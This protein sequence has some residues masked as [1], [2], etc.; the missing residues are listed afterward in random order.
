MR[1]TSP[2]DCLEYKGS[3]VSL[4]Q[5]KY[6]VGTVLDLRKLSADDYRYYAKCV[7]REILKDTQKIVYKLKREGY[8]KGMVGKKMLPGNKEQ[9]RLKLFVL[10]NAHTIEIA[11]ASPRG[12]H[13]VGTVGN[14]CYLQNGQC[15][16][17][18]S[19]DYHL[20]FRCEH[21]GNQVVYVHR[22]PIIGEAYLKNLLV[23]PTSAS[24]QDLMA[25]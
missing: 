9:I 15:H 24:P 22:H 11:G 21:E 1:A 5:P 17:G 3:P 13:V 12:M 14:E 2:L 23:T 6:A 10:K 18:V 16:S 7:L 4:P 20:L 25:A 8:M 19:Y